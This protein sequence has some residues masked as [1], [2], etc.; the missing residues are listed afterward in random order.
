MIKLRKDKQSLQQKL[1]SIVVYKDFMQER[2]L[3]YNNLSIEIDIGVSDS[4]SR[5]SDDEGSSI[6][7]SS[8]VDSEISI[9]QSEL[10]DEKQLLKP[11][12][13]MDEI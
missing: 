9:Q 5:S 1:A 8:S 4:S 10:K 6:S 13:E 3:Y 7:S 12:K 2:M 11:E